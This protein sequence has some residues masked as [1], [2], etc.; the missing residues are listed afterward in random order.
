MAVPMLHITNGDCAAREIAALALPG[1]ILPWRD[2][3]HDGPLPRPGTLESLRSLRAGFLADGDLDA[4]VQI[5]Q[6]LACRDA[7][8]GRSHGEDEVVL[9]FEHD[10]Y[11]QLQLAQILARYAAGG[12]PQ[13]LTLAQSDDYLGHMDAP[14]LGVVF[15][16]RRP[17]TGAQ[18]AAAVA[19]W[20]ALTASDPRELEAASGAVA[21]LPFM[22]AALR[23][24]LEELPG[25]ADGLSRTERQ[26]LE[27]L[28]HQPLSFGDLY[29]RA[30]H[31][32]EDPT[33]LGDSS[34]VRL[35]AALAGAGGLVAI[36]GD[37]VRSPMRC[38]VSLTGAGRAVLAQREDRVRLLGID[39]WIGG[40]HLEGRETRW[41]WDGRG[42]GVVIGDW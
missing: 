35:V 15:A 27:A 9:W 41:R 29:L 40:I 3:L 28:E 7:R 33:F 21:A 8:V 42:V 22:A 26:A 38:L 14:S 10:L 17:V 23:R 5:E 25:S 11:D 20:D 16:G 18:F 32:R 31:H 24:L 37:R 13:R 34:F 39:R 2:V 36:E 19:A 12:R 4:A 6:D 30:H 1:E